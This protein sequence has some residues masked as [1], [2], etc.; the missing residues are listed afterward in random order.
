M[1]E[2]IRLWPVAL[3]SLNAIYV[4]QVFGPAVVPR[5]VLIVT[6]GLGLQRLLRLSPRSASCVVLGYGHPRVALQVYFNV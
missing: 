2:H 3:R 5:C 6:Q 4:M 1:L